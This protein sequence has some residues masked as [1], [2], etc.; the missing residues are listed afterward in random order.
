MILQTEAAEC[1][2][3]CVAMVASYWGHHVDLSSIR[4][5]Y[6]TSLRGMGLRALMALAASVGLQARPLKLDLQHLQQLK[7]PCILHLDMNHFVVLQAVHRDAVTIHDPAVGAR[8]WTFSEF[9]E[10]FTGVALELM[11][12]PEFRSADRRQSPAL[13]SLL[14]R[15]VGLRRA[16]LQ[17][18]VLGIA[19]QVCVLTA[20]FYLQWVVDE[21]LVSADR[22]LI[23]VLGVGF[24]LLVVL[25]AVLSSFRS[26]V[27]NVL[28]VNLSFQ[29]LGNA[30]E[31]LI[32]LPLPFFEKRH[33]GDIV[34]RFG[35]IQTIQKSLTSQLVEACIDGLLAITTLGVMLIYSLR[36][37][38]V[39]VASA[40]FYGVLRRI[41][42]EP[43][44]T[45]TTDRSS[46]VQGNRVIS[47][48]PRGPCKASGCSSA[49]KNGE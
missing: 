12:G 8:R 42:H 14:G 48:S 19:L 26:W 15:V 18:F 33:L 10:H 35:S 24:L 32:R 43:L 17:A 30:F 7:L 25:Q 40:V 9:S 5:D 29:W 13:S 34:S 41:L 21:A 38:C 3:A 39:A 1:G 20:P 11:P 37:S 2:L 31:H 28:S 47:S 45:A 22:N 4:R 27:A 46:M 6:S 44:R 49:R 23:T 36:L 16:L